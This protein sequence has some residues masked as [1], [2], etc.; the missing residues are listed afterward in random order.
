MQSTYSSLVQT[1]K[2]FCDVCSNE[3]SI[4]YVCQKCK[5]RFCQEHKSPET[6]NC[7]STK[8]STPINNNYFEQNL[9]KMEPDIKNTYYQELT[10]ETRK[11]I[12]Q[13]LN[14]I[15]TFNQTILKKQE[16]VEPKKPLLQRY[17]YPIAIICSFTIITCI[18][19]F[20]Y[21]LLK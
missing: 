17:A 8:K 18:S 20:I 4:S 12:N 9:E 21:L 14:Q 5:G 16:N 3:L 19:S 11:K 13:V 1:S 10:K 2:V 6:H 7:I 15:D